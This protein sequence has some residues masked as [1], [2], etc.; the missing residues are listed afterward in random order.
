MSSSF[1]GVDIGGTTTVIGLLDGGSFR[2]AAAIPTRAAEGPDSLFH[3]IAELTAEADCRPLAIGVGIAGLVDRD[4]GLL[5]FSPNLPGWV[6]LDVAAGLGRMCG[7]PVVV[8]NDC[9]AFAY[10]AISS[11]L[12]PSEGLRLFLTL[13]TGI[14]GTII[15]QGRILHGTGHAGEFGHMPV[16]ASGLP[17]P[18]GSTGC[19]ERYAG[20]SALLGYCRER[21]ADVSDSLEAADLARKGSGKC[22]SAFSEFGRWVGIGLAGLANCFSPSGFHLAGGL[23][24]AWDLF[25]GSAK[26]TFTA[27]CTHPWE[28]GVLEAS[29]DAGASG[30]AMLA[31]DFSG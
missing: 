27:R 31:R 19:W 2:K 20:L 17:C 7:V 5:S 22:I 14:G 18:C 16:E 21:G 30:A 3:R 8:E 24:G 1:W 13:G 9:N 15:H 11:G 4:R 6:E 23:A 26:T 25:E 28:V 12:V 10:G 29:S